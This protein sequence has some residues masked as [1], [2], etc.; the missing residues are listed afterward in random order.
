MVY[1]DHDWLAENLKPMFRVLK[2]QEA[3]YGYQS[4]VV[5]EAC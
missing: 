5:V 4:A 3:A 2:V 1:Y